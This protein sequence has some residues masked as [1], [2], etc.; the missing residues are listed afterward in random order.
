MEKTLTIPKIKPVWVIIGI[1][2]ATF[3]AVVAACVAVIGV[4]LNLVMSSGGSAT[5]QART[6][7]T[8]TPI[9]TQTAPPTFALPTLN[10]PTQ[11]PLPG[12][13]PP[14]PFSTPI[15]SVP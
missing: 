15:N 13:V 4:S 6:G 8:P 11:I 5:S 7:G 3:C 1:G 14:P 9:V 12:I 10:A 2:V